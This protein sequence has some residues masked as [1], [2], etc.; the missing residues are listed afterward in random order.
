MLKISLFILI[1]TLVSSCEYNKGEVKPAVDCS[2]VIP[3]TV[4]FSADIVPVLTKSCATAGCHS[5]ASPQG[6]LNLE[7]NNAY[8]QLNKSG[9]GYLNVS[10]PHNSILYISLVSTTDPMPPTGA[11]DPCAVELIV[12]WMSQGTKNN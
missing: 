3:S 1:L 11:L 8:A 2:T 4:S 10:N 9:S 12:K 7:A 6:N 5:G